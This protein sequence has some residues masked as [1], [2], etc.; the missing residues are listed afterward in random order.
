MK[1]LPLLWAN[2]RRKPLR[3]ALT[4]AS[5]VVAF[6]LFG[7]L[8]TVSSA[9]SGSI[10]LAGADRLITMHKLSL[11][12][13]FPQSYLTRIRGVDGV[14]A[15]TSQDWFGGIYQDDRNQ[16]VAL[17]VDPES[18][19]EV[20]PEYNLTPEQR[21]AWLADRTGAIVG[22]TLAATHGWKAGDTIPLRSNFY[23]KADG[24]SVWD[25]E[26]IAVF[27]ASNGDNSSLYFHYDY[28]NESRTA[29]RDEIGYV[30]LR[31][32][33]PDRA[34]QVAGTID[35]MFANSR[36]ET[37]TSTEKAFIQGFANQMGNIGAIVTTVATAVFF[38]ML[39]VT[40][41]TMA[42]SVR[43]RT[44]EIAVLKTLG[45]SSRGVTGPVLAESLL[46]TALGGAVGLGIAAL[47][48]GALAAVVQQYFPTL[49]I[50]AGTYWI[51]TALII[52]LG[53]L[54]GLWPSA[55][56]WRLRITD[57]LRKV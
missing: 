2:L 8:Q 39:L 35:A 24:S 38:T 27:D 53:V 17:A 34:P 16:I 52:V 55:Q 9:L 54:A 28:L 13:S 6:L 49:G 50:P 1:Y 46:I 23:T 41:N 44:N 30:A 25:L 37:K 29:Q 11:I 21:A 31:I 47:A 7:L 45:F 5:I 48:A 20:Y 42:Q 14:R 26:I 18:F 56:A 33:D 3:S 57:A 15:A 43:E 36:A 12:M 10:G 32:A 40:A 4:F 22:K 19:L 51:G